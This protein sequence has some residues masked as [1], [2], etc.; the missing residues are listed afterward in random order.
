MM[1]DPVCFKD[2][3]EHAAAADGLT[4]E[5][6]GQTQYFCSR[7]CKDRYDADPTSFG[8]RTSDFQHPDQAVD[9]A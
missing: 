2:V 7:E 3:D 5:R 4:S 8:M 1:K 9:R 6:D